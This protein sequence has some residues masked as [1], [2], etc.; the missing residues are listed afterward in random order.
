MENRSGGYRLG[1]LAL[2]M[3]A[4]VTLGVTVVAA[5][6]VNAAQTSTRLTTGSKWTINSELCPIREIFGSPGQV[7]FIEYGN[8]IH[9]SGK[10]RTNGTTL[11]EKVPH[12]VPG[13][14]AFSG[15]WSKTLKGYIGTLTNGVN[16]LS[17][18]LTP[19]VVKGCP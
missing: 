5:G 14:L 16:H 12:A 11:M 2:A 4:F 8:H 19:G 7:T 6:P 1:R 13:P 3:A 9:A 15:S 10:Y 18:T 17:A